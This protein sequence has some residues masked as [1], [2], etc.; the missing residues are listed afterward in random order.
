MTPYCTAPVR[1][2]SRRLRW[3]QIAAARPPTSKRCSAFISGAPCMSLPEPDRMV[4]PTT[5]RNIGQSIRRLEAHEKVTGR[6]EYVHHLR[7][8]RMLIGKIFRSAVPHAR[9]KR[10]DVSA[11]QALEGVYRVVTIDDIRSVIP[12]PYYGPAFHDQPFLAAGKVR[13]IADPVSVV[14]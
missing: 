2:R 1:P 12:H 10:I 5:S 9:I 11:A 6:A 7:L 14:P 8:P 3:R 4:S 13:C